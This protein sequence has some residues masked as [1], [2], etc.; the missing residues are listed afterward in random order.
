MKTFVHIS[1]LFLSA[2]LWQACKEKPKPAANPAT[3]I[4]IVLEGK[5][6]DVS[7][8][9]KR[10]KEALIE[11]LYQ[12]LI[13]KSEELKQLDA[14]IKGL[15][16]LQKQATDSFHLFDSKNRAY[17]ESALLTTTSIRD[18]IFRKKVQ[19]IINESFNAYKTQ[20]LPHQLLDSLLSQKNTTITDLY[21]LLKVVKTLPAMHNF[22]EERLPGTATAEAFSR[23]LDSL[24]QK[25]DTLTAIPKP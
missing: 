11:S 13:S 2:L 4:P 10:N 25:L 6:V 12:E 9:Y 17:Y 24:V 5:H 15:T 20:I 14:E 22:Q 21:I 18:S 1:I 19:G 23:Q 16:Q 3:N 8:L 7:S